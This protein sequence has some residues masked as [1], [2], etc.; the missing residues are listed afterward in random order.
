MTH[1]FASQAEVKIKTI[2]PEQKGSGKPVRI[3]KK[4]E[5]QKKHIKRSGKK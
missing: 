3:D 2:R 5:C 4:P 1:E